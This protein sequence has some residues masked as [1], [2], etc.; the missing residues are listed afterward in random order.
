MLFVGDERWDFHGNLREPPFE[1]IRPFNKAWLGEEMVVN[2][3]KA[4]YIF[5][6]GS[7]T[8]GIVGP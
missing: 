5:L 1:E 3:L 6:G 2:P 4:G 7:K 8:V